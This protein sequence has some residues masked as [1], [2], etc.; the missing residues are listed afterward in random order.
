[1]L[2]CDGWAPVHALAQQLG[3]RGL[4]RRFLPHTQL[5]PAEVSAHL[6]ALQQRAV[7]EAHLASEP[8]RT[9]TSLR[10]LHRYLTA[11]PH[12]FVVPIDLSALDAC[13]AFNSENLE[14]FVSWCLAVLDSTPDTLSGYVSAIT[15]YCRIEAG[16]PVFSADD[17][18]PDQFRWARQLHAPAG[19]RQLCL[20]LGGSDFSA[21]Y[22]TLSPSSPAHICDFAVGHA[23]YEFTLRGGEVGTV[24]GASIDVSRDLVLG[25]IQW[26]AP[27][28]TSGGRLWGIGL[29]CACK[30]PQAR[31]KPV[32]IPFVCRC[33]PGSPSPS[34]HSN[35]TEVVYVYVYG[36]CLRYGV[37]RALRIRIRMRRGQHQKM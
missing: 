17:T 28:T 5:R 19:T 16:R 3:L 9:L 1:M 14:A 2:L 35:T 23:A 33:P 8:G 11:F 25:S 10:H 22:P 7:D 20:G 26:K 31:R 30:D 13:L 34:P 4:R 36:G 24:D 12:T 21:I 32:P 15:T 18:R 37:R 6:L 27:D 29:V